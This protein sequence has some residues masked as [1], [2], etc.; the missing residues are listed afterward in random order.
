MKLNIPS[1]EMLNNALQCTRRLMRREIY[2]E[3]G[4]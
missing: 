4:I 1:R 2:M 3:E